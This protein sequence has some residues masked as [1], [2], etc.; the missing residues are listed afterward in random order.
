MAKRAV[1]CCSVTTHVRRVLPSTVQAPGGIVHHR[2]S[3]K[4]QRTT[5]YVPCV[6]RPFEWDI[7][8][9]VNL[10]TCCYV[11]RVSWCQRVC[12]S[13]Y[14]HQNVGTTNVCRCE[15]ST[16]HLVRHIRWC[17]VK[18]GVNSPKFTHRFTQDSHESEI[19]NLVRIRTK[20]AR[21]WPTFHCFALLQLSKPL[22]DNVL[23][24]FLA[25][26][27]AVLARCCCRHPGAVSSPSSRPSLDGGGDLPVW[28]PR[29]AGCSGLGS[30]AGP[31]PRGYSR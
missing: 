4:R 8:V 14:L 3:T 23:N 16:S 31:H 2:T 5:L 24:S 30:I 17:S 15:V 11:L 28:G 22:F 29:S 13:C 10:A 6:K 18:C 26:V 20:F 1:G 25:R 12:F 27:P 19:V 9:S 21:I 7:H